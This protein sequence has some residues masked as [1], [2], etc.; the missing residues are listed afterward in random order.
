M[1]EVFSKY[2]LIPILTA[3]LTTVA[4]YLKD[5]FIESKKKKKDLEEKQILELYNKLF[6]IFLKYN[7]ELKVSWQEEVIDLPEDDSPVIFR[8]LV[9][10]NVETWNAVY[11]EVSELVHE[12]IHLL[13]YEDLKAWYD[14]EFY[15]NWIETEGDLY[16]AFTAFKKFIKNTVDTWSPI[17]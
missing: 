1:D 2:L 6:I 4:V 17:S 12:K 14:V 8:E 15:Y 13:D 3:V 5:F 16:E 9:I 11:K 7:H 10:D